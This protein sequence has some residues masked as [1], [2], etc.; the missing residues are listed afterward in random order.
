MIFLLVVRLEDL[1]SSTLIA[2]SLARRLDVCGLTDTL[3]QYDTPIRGIIL[4]LYRFLIIL[5]QLVW[6]NYVP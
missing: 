5:P 3:N 2:L 1:E 4:I 6:G